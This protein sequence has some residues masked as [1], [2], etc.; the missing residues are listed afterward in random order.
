MRSNRV[1]ANKTLRNVNKA[2]AVSRSQKKTLGPGGL[3][4]TEGWR[5]GDSDC[6]PQEK[7]NCLLGIELS[8][9]RRMP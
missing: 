6:N 5:F 7:A 8:L 2:S 1:T 4:G 3:E 9:F